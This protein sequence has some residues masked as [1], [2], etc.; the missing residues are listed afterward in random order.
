MDRVLVIGGVGIGVYQMFDSLRKEHTVADLPDLY[1]GVLA[2][3]MWL[4]YQARQGAN[5][6]ALY[7]GAAFLLQL[8]LITAVYHRDRERRQYGDLWRGD[9]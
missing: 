6:S 5:A 8:Y 3:L 9:R 7:S 1:L 2:S 4:V